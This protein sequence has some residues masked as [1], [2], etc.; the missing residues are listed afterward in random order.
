MYEFIYKLIY[1]RRESMNIIKVRRGINGFHYSVCDENGY[2]VIN[3]E[4]LGDVRK[5]YLREIRWGHVKLVRE[6][7]K[8]PD[9]SQLEAAKKATESLLRAYAAAL[10][11][12]NEKRKESM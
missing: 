1:E 7:D 3:A 11:R 10:N 5:Y 12:E 2:F 6:L 4:K 8:Q 9:L